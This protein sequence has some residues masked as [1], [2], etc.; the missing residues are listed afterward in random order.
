[1]KITCLQEN[2][3]FGLQTTG[4]LVNKN[5]NLP[6]LNNVLLEAKEGSLKLSSTNLEIGISSVVRCKVEKEGSF[7]VDARLLADYVNLL[8][9]DQV[10]MELLAD[11]FMKIA[12]LSSETKMKG[13]VADDFPVI[14]QIEKKDPFT[15][16]IS[17]FKKALS[18]VIFSVASSE[19]RPE[20]SGI[21]MNFN[22]LSKNKLVMVGTD[23]YRL[24]E[25]FVELEKNEQEQEVIV[26]LKTLQELLRILGNLKDKADTP[27]NLEIYITENQVLFTCANIELISRLLEGQYPDY[28]QII[29]QETK[30]KI[31]TSTSEL[32]K[33]IKKVAL[34]SKT[35]IFDIN[36]V[37]EAQK[38]L[39]VQATNSQLGES[40]A[41]IDVE[42]TGETNDTTLNYRYLLDGLNNVDASEVEISLVDNNL[43][44]LIRPKGTTDYLY[45]VMPIKQ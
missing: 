30:T 29:P 27:E 39:T 1:M 9:K 31:I 28:K 36:L 26:P 22:K 15:I 12:C 25:K 21:L 8:A 6:I 5:I 17:D 41:D 34:F 38:G 37:F 2:L 11:D 45:I 33:A 18:Q 13:I 43:P 7:T 44:C 10:N 14:P 16:K 20:I 32:V 4:H 35:G 23:S 42:F 40:K 19:T 3:N 24:A